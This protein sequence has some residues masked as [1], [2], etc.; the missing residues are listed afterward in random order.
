MATPIDLACPRCKAAPGRACHTPLPD[1]V[2]VA[3]VRLKSG[4]HAERE[5]ALIAMQNERARM[6]EDIRPEIPSAPQSTQI[7][8]IELPCLCATHPFPHYHNEMD[9][10]TAM[11][12]F[13]AKAAPA[14]D[15][16]FGE[17]PA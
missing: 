3:W 5:R 17:V 14:V 10:R 9:W 2:A 15:H 11:R 6:P 8:E 12:R 7:V 13:R 16:P 1:G 4:F